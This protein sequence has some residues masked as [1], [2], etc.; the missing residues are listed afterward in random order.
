M[1]L[2]IK[3]GIEENLYSSFL[4]Q[5]GGRRDEEEGEG[6]GRGRGEEE[7]EKEGQMAC[8]LTSNYVPI[9]FNLPGH[10]RGGL[11]GPCK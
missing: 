1:T 7:E 8:V 5:G 6:K 4:H 9:L 11:Q 3:E 2:N 10:D